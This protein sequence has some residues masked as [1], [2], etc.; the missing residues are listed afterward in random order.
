MRYSFL[1]DLKFITIPL[2]FLYIQ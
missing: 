2:Q 1:I